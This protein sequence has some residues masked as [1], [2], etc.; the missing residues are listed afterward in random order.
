MEK[1]PGKGISGGST[2]GKIKKGYMKGQAKER[3]E[4]AK[5]WINNQM[6]QQTNNV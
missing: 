4:Q 5:K 2:D 6:N 1:W 3:N